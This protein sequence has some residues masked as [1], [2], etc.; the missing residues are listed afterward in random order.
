MSSVRKCR[1]IVQES[2]SAISQDNRYVRVVRELQTETSEYEIT[3]IDSLL[4]IYFRFC[5]GTGTRVLEPVLYC[6]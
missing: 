4:R 1:L 5:K 2:T 3:I 6:S